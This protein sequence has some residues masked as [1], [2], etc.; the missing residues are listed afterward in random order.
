MAAVAKQVQQLARQLFK[1]SLVDGA[2]SADRVSGVLQYV[3]KH[4]PANTLA[5]LKVY[6]RLVA[7]E[8]ARG[9]ALVE[10]AGPVNESVLSSIAAAMTQKYR[11]KVASIA[12]PNPALLAGLRVR[13]GDDVYE[14]SVAGQLASL[15]ASV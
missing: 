4:R 6:Q 11:R 5:V 15:G 8:V 1:L 3:E 14:S 12:R 2:L 13:V 9:Q 7:A 10:H